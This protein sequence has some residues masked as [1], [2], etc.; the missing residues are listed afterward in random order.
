MDGRNYLVQWYVE[1]AQ[2]DCIYSHG[3]SEIE[4]LGDGTQ[5][6]ARSSFSE[7]IRTRFPRLTANDHWAQELGEEGRI[8]SS[9]KRA[10]RIVDRTV[11]C[12]PNCSQSQ[13]D[14]SVE[15]NVGGGESFAKDGIGKQG[16]KMK[17]GGKRSQKRK[18][19]LLSQSSSQEK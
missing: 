9:P 19:N 8:Q 17:R 15:E 18:A 2:K 10:K 4:K 12:S 6:L 1:E 5:A 11:E 16:G 13:G 14:E 3:G 7:E